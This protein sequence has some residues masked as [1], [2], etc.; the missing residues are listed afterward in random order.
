MRVP[1]VLCFLQTWA[2][3]LSRSSPRKA[4]L[5][6]I[7]RPDIAY[8]GQKDAQQAAVIRRM[9]KDLFWPME[10]VVC[11]TVR[12]ADGLAM[13]SRN[14]YLSDAQRRQARSLSAALFG[15]RDQIQSGQRDVA[16]LVADIRRSIEAAGPSTIEYIEIVDA[17]DLTPLQ[18]IRGRCLVA[19]AVRIG[20]TRLIDNVLVDAG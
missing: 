2:Q 11:P 17:E 1:I 3:R 8:F 10:I 4:K 14:V 12:E 19:L 7:I 20:A 16:G 5:F 13:S 6:A 18:A 9:V 15:A